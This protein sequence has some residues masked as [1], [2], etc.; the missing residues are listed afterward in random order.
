[1]ADKNTSLRKRTLISKAGKNMFVWVVVASIVLSFAVVVSSILIQR[2]VSVND[3]IG[4]KTST[5]KILQNNNK[6]IPDLQNAVRALNSNQNLIDSKA[7]PTDEALQVVLDAL[8]SEGN[9]LALGAS[10]QQKLLPGGDI[11]IESLSITPISGLESQNTATTNTNSVSSSTNSSNSSDLRPIKYT[12]A[13]KGST[14]SLV[15]LLKRIE[16]SIRVIDTSSL[17]IESH[18]TIQSMVVSGQAYYQPAR[19]FK[20]TTEKT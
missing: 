3:T 17:S 7:N 6:A 18:G 13:V 1:V 8:P 16:S 5:L 9:S 12:F 10:F 2:I 20:V 19:V 15:E 4:K 14:T 11:T